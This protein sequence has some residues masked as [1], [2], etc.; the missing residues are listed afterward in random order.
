M[1]RVLYSLI[2]SSIPFIS[3]S[4]CSGFLAKIQLEKFPQKSQITSPNIALLNLHLST[5]SH[6]LNYHPTMPTT[7]VPLF[8]ANV[9]VACHQRR[10][11]SPS[12]CRNR[13]I[14]PPPVAYVHLGNLRL[15]GEKVDAEGALFSLFHRHS[16]YGQHACWITVAC[17]VSILSSLCSSSC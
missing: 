11:K 14:A 1:V 6:W 16:F 2:C 7:M 10:S 9:H 4:F 12:R 3:L 8:D 5:Q 17:R 15:V 13:W